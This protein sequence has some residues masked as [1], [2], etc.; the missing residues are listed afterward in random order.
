MEALLVEEEVS[1][2]GKHETLPEPRR[3]HTYMNCDDPWK[4][5]FVD[6]AGHVRP[7]CGTERVMGDLADKTFPDI[8]YGDEYVKFRKALLSGQPPDE[9]LSCIHRT[10]FYL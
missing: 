5:A 8:W 4:F 6:C 7:C 3:M 10:K 2:D 1:D 9:C